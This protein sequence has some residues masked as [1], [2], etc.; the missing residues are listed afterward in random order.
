MR[1]AGLSATAGLSCCVC[2][3]IV[4]DMV[5]AD[6]Q[7]A[8]LVKRCVLEAI[9]LHSPGTIARRVT[10]SFTLHVSIGSCLCY[11]L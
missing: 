4:A 5:L 10:K 6:L 3:E 2:D 11:L 1:R 9:R 7:R 8:P